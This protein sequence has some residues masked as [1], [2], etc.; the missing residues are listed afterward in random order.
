MEVADALQIF[1]IDPARWGEVANSLRPRPM[2]HR[3]LLLYLASVIG[4]LIV[5]GALVSLM[6]R[7]DRQSGYSNATLL[8]WGLC[9]LHRLP[10]RDRWLLWQAA[11]AQ[12][13][14]DPA[15][16]FV[17]AARY[18]VENLGPQLAAHPRLT[19][20]RERLIGPPGPGA[21]AD[22][23]PLESA[24][25]SAAPPAPSPLRPAQPRPTLDLG[26]DA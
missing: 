20:L 6:S 4:V 2:A 15:L 23:K 26:E 19:Q 8:F 14:R 3:D 13:L 24:A 11:R 5:F 12:R 1:A 16:M 9:R 22:V 10:L 21:V 25:S 18:R 17:D 7:R